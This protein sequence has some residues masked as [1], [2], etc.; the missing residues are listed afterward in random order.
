[1]RFK[2]FFLFLFSAQTCCVPE[3]ACRSAAQKNTLK[4]TS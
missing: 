4:K 3:C 1:M 2:V